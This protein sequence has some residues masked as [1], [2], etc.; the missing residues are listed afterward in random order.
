M[1]DVPILAAVVSRDPNE[2]TMKCA[3]IIFPAMQ[4]SLSC[5][6]F[7]FDYRLNFI[8]KI[9]ELETVNEL[10]ALLKSP[11]AE[12]SGHIVI[13]TDKSML[14]S[15][16]D[17]KKAPLIKAFLDTVKK[18][19][20]EEFVF[21]C[22]V[23]LCHTDAFTKECDN[24]SD[25]CRE[26]GFMYDKFIISGKVG[27]IEAAPS[28]L[29]IAIAACAFFESEFRDKC[30][31]FVQKFRI[32]QQRKTKHNE[33]N[34]ILFTVGAV[35][36][37]RGYLMEEILF[38]HL[39]IIPEY[40]RNSLSPQHNTYREIIVKSSVT[41]P[42]ILYA[43]RTGMQYAY[44]I[45]L[46][47]KCSDTEY[48]ITLGKYGTAKQIWDYILHNALLYADIKL[49]EIP[50]SCVYLELMLMLRFDKSYLENVTRLK[51]GNVP[52]LQ[53]IFMF[54]AEIY[55]SLFMRDKNISTEYFE[56]IKC[57]CE[58]PDM[59]ADKTA[60]MLNNRNGGDVYWPERS[61]LFRLSPRKNTKPD[62]EK[63]YELACELQE[64][65][66]FHTKDTEENFSVVLSLYNTVCENSPDD[67]MFAHI[68]SAVENYVKAIGQYVSPDDYPHIFS[69]EAAK[70]SA[71]LK[72]A[73]SRL[74]GKKQEEGNE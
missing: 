29:I 53:Q 62:Y 36:F 65:Y 28:A 49:S 9:V 58:D 43:A 70:R 18:H 51:D 69:C 59:V 10:E 46:S 6:Y 39:Y 13:L 38:Q 67:C 45:L 24:F 57:F 22:S 35:V 73:Y 8:G 37:S 40:L 61:A 27:R 1:K 7:E 16:P 44:N 66:G 56:K 71:Q 32:F 25:L 4:K 48:F 64:K 54:E 31:L 12:K 60:N 21:K 23:I 30:G 63:C 42:L 41:Y 72:A 19:L 68:L 47:A 74:T 50:F 14:E 33:F 26:Y 11:E 15:D 5:A 34:H 3:E 2:P 20:R 52:I 55:F 17:N